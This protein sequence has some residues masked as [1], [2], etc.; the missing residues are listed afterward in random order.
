ME[1][2]RL[3]QSIVVVGTTRSVICQ[4]SY[5]RIHPDKREGRQFVRRSQ[6]TNNNNQVETECRLDY[7]G[8]GKTD[9]SSNTNYVCTKFDQ[10]GY[11]ITTCN[12]KFD[13]VFDSRKSNGDD[14]CELDR[15]MNRRKHRSNGKDVYNNA[16]YK[17]CPV[18]SSDDTSKKRKILSET[19]VSTMSF[20][21]TSRSS[22]SKLNAVHVSISL[23]TLEQLGNV[24]E[25][26]FRVTSNGNVR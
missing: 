19:D 20:T 4:E 22:A 17:R 6:N 23:S 18:S 5:N 16:H 12:P 9:K 26:S 13:E 10:H 15:R 8:P 25:F 24:G 7:Y 3:S 2:K 1:N 14:R 11:P 21:Q